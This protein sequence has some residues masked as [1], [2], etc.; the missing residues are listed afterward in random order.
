MK[1]FLLSISFLALAGSTVF[2]LTISGSAHD[3][4]TELGTD[5]ICLPCH[6][7]HNAAPAVPLWNHAPG[8]GSYTVYD[9]VTLDSGPATISG[10]TA[11]CLSCHDDSIAVGS[12]VNNA[13]SGTSGEITQ[14]TSKMSVLYSGTTA[15]LGEDLS[16]DHPVSFTYD[17][18]LS[19]TDTGLNDPGV[20]GVNLAVQ[21]FG[22]SGN[23]LEC[24]TCHNVHDNAIEPFLTMSNT[25]SLLCLNCH[26][27]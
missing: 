5:Q 25:G 23:Q 7:P 19:G 11:L 27:K 8:T 13:A 14:I 10:I 2:A 20:D 4:R 3:M 21:L 9:S 15:A 6:T 24:A 26:A 22:P 17:T 1:R 18:A 12:V 16:N